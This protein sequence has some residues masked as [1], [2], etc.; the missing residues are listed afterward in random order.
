[1]IGK[2]AMELHDLESAGRTALAIEQ[3]Q[4][5]NG[6]TC[7]GLWLV[8]SAGQ[9]WCNVVSNGDMPE[10]SARIAIHAAQC[11]VDELRQRIPDFDSV[12]RQLPIR[13]AVV[14]DYGQGVAPLF[15]LTDEGLV[16][17]DAAWSAWRR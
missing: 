7:R 11:A 5:G 14:C 16:S 13:Y 2:S 12:A 4:C 9:L 15:C 3:L 10:S 17:G 6:F 8:T 1:M